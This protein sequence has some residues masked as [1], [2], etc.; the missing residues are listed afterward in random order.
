MAKAKLP[1][2]DLQKGIY[3]RIDGEE[4][5]RHT[6]NWDTLKKIGDSAQKLISKLARYSLSDE[7]LGED[8]VKL[9]F[10]GFYPG[11]AVPAWDI[12]KPDNLLFA[13]TASYK[14]LNQVFSFVLG[15]LDDGNFQ[16][17]ADKYNEPSVKNEIVDAV[18]DFS[19][20][21][22]TRPFSVVR[23]AGKDKFR[24][25]AKIRTITPKHKEL[26]KVPDIQKVTAASS[27]TEVEGVSKVLVK[28]SIKGRTT[29]KISHLYTQ[30]EVIVSLKFDSIETDSR[31]YLL[32]NNLL[33]DI[34]E[35][36]KAV[37]IES[38]MLDIY[39]F[40]ETLDEAE[41]DLFDQFDYTFQRLN[42]F[43]DNKLSPHLL[44]A[45]KY[46]N[47]LVEKVKDK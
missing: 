39:A 6:I 45:K 41:K 7:P 31:I 10:I 21:A 44:N 14:E 18:A 22:G 20:S 3:L 13:K 17:I 34:T 16:A 23:P 26:L 2:V 36:K 40:G 1:P 11:S 9:E 28:T 47:L 5:K 8:S 32:R 24:S 30:K 37:T 15:R 38:P 33:V 46:I 25:I 12:K 29:K 4:E 19:A 27:A 43:A 42:Q 35:G